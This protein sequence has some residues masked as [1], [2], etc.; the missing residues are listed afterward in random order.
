[1]DCFQKTSLCFSQSLFLTYK[2]KIYSFLKFKLT[3]KR[4]YLQTTNAKRTNLHRIYLM[5]SCRF[6]N[7]KSENRFIQEFQLRFFIFTGNNPCN[8]GVPYK[9]NDDAVTCSQRKRCPSGHVCTT[10]KGY[11]VCCPGNYTNYEQSTQ[12]SLRLL[13]RRC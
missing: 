13:F 12:H 5:G 7:I 4:S 11:A 10:G 2:V 9:V 6:L 8:T 1:M 3:K